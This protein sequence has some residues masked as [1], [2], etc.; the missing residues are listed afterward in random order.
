MK[1]NVKWK[2]VMMVVGMLVGGLSLPGYSSDWVRVAYDDAGVQNAQPHFKKATANWQVPNT[3]AFDEALRTVVFGPYIWFGYGGMNPKAEY[4]AKVRFLAD[5]RRVMRVKAGEITVLESVATEGGKL[6]EREIVLPPAAYSAGSLELVFELI[7]DCNGGMVSDVEILSTDPKPL[8]VSNGTAPANLAERGETVARRDARM[9]WFREARFGMFIHWGLYAVAAGEW[10]GKPVT[11]AADGNW[12]SNA[13]EWIMYDA[14]IPIADYAAMVSKFNPVKYDPEKWVLAAKAAGM[15]YMVITTKHHEGFAMFKTAATPFNIIDATPYKRDPMKELAAACR[16]HGMKLGF[17]YSQNLDWHHPGGGGNDWDKAHQGDADQYVDKIVIPQVREILKNYGDIAVI[18]WDIPGGA[19]NKAR[20]DRIYK[21]VL[22][23]QPKIVMNNRL[24]GGYWGDTETPEQHIPATG[25]PGRDWETCMT[26][27]NTWGFK[28]LDNKWKSAETM[29]QMLCD[30]ASKGGNYLLNVGP[31]A[32]GEI[33]QE[34]L[35]RLTEIGKWMKVNGQAIYGTSAT[36]FPQGVPWGRV[37]QK[38]NS[39]YL[40]VFTLPADRTLVLPGLTTKAKKARFLDSAIK[41]KL[42]VAN[43][44]Q[45]VKVTVPEGAVMNP[46]STVIVLKL[47][48]KP[49]VAVAT[50]NSK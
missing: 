42:V 1:S 27:N 30:I 2:Q 34:S 7:S 28:S 11:T 26:M 40:M 50:G 18:W 12:F 25:Y 4:K 47:A 10:N 45:G 19:I 13:G 29:I 31:T 15:K 9:K 39:L 35:D 14:R 46:V 20:A 21:T 6:V 36:P 17:Y 22:E 43:D 16:K 48:G 33:P 44:A 23:L 32:D 41:A 24:G 3:E 5:G 8:G 38:G 37:T 49:D